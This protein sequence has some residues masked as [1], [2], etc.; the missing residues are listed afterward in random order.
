MLSVRPAAVAGMF[1]PGNPRALA[2]EVDDLLGGVSECAPRLGYPKALIVPHA[3]YI[4]SGGV[5][6]RAYDE[7]GPARGSVKRVVLLGPT[8]RVAMRGLAMPSAGGFATPLGTVRVDTAA[9]DSVRDLPQVVVSDAAH[10]M[11]HS[12]EVQLPF[13]QKMLG[14]FALAP[15]AVGMASVAEVAEVI[16][17]L[18][19]G[20]ETLVV[21]STDMSH[22]HSYGQARAI[23]GSTIKRIA[24]FATDIHHEEACGATPLNGLLFFSKQ[25][26]LSLKLLAACNSG[27]TAGGKDR[28]VGYSAFGLYEGRAV[29]LEEAGRMLLSLARSCIEKNLLG[30]PG[31]TPSAAWLNQ[32]GATF[33][34]LTKEGALRGCIGSLEPARALAEDVTENALGA[35][36]R[37]PRFPAMT[38]AE[39]PLCRVEVS[40]LSTRKP[41]RFAD[42]ADLLEQIEAGEDGLIIEADGRRGTFLPQVWEDLG[43]KRV[44]L[45]HL[46][47]KAGLP[48]DTPLTRCNISRYRV[49]K[50]KE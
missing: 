21:I 44:F 5:A 13:L 3:G 2:A 45:S 8:H 41:L 38:A 46:V 39:W 30:K 1:Y 42:E 10:A 37:D 22:Y 48:A 11:E 15:F 32:T 49:A 20:P 36:F 50:W 43:D 27:D 31:L 29:L 4:Y 9:L 26:N 28:V 35:A 23:D 17:R 16:E 6:A 25:K 14:D 24:E 40:L 18:W 19:G 12:L 7:L 34:T 33:V 47:R